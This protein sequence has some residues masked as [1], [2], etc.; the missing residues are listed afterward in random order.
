MPAFG[1]KY[2]KNSPRY[3]YS[4]NPLPLNS[5]QKKIL[6][7]VGN[8]KNRF[9]VIDGPPGT[10]KSHTIGAVTY[11][12]NQNNKSIVITSHK[13]E[14]LDVVERMLTDKFKGLHPHSK[15]SVIRISKSNGPA[16]LI[17]AEIPV[18]TGN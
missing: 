2:P 15:P 7:A 17:S 11:W 3:F 8:P 12:A 9:V 14:A 6:K 4:D 13:T 18:F 1:R 16:T 10:G 5:S